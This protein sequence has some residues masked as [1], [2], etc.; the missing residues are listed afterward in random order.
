MRCSEGMIRPLG[1]SRLSEE[2]VRL[3]E[4]LG[5]DLADREPMNRC[6]VIGIDELNCE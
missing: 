2:L 5:K 6:V 4:E 1:K 3:F